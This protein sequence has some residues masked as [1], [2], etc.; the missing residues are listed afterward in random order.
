MAA[1]ARTKAMIDGRFGGADA[2]ANIGTKMWLETKRQ[3]THEAETAQDEVRERGGVVI[4]QQ[5]AAFIEREQ[6]AEG[7]Q[8]HQRRQGRP[9][10]GRDHRILCAR[11]RLSASSP[12][13]S[14]SPVA[15]TAAATIRNDRLRPIHP[16]DER[17]HPGDRQPEHQLDRP[18]RD[19]RAAVA[20]GSNWTEAPIAVVTR[21]PSANRCTAASVEPRPP[22]KLATSPAPI[23]STSHIAT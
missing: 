16:G 13:N 6:D 9:A 17:D 8:Q 11:R 19:D 20:T 3:Q 15:V 22:R 18:D 7:D 12:P 1:V 5:V 4:G 21:T 10:I 14:S 23:S 2:S